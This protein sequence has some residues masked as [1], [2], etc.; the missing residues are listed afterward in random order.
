[1]R[2]HEHAKPVDP[3]PSHPTFGRQAYNTAELLYTIERAMACPLNPAAPC[4]NCKTA[5]MDALHELQIKHPSPP[6]PA[7]QPLH[8]ASPPRPYRRARQ[9]PQQ[10]TLPPLQP[11]PI[12]PG[13]TA[14][15]APKPPNADPTITITPTDQTIDTPPGIWIH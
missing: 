15:L 3:N 7:A 14:P 2:Y 8:L 6:Q 12:R 9:L 13:Q 10:L 4:H 1:M 5:I 11:Q